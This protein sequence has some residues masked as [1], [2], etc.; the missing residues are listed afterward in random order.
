MNP[1]RL[2]RTVV[3]SRYAIRL[4]PD[5]TTFTFAGDE[6]VTV[7][8]VEPVTEIRLNAVELTITAVII[9]NAR[10]ES[11]HGTAHA[12]PADERYR[13]TFPAPIAPGEWRLRLAFTGTLNDKL[14][15]FYR[16][17]YKD[18]SGVP[19]ALAATQPETPT[20]NALGLV[21]ATIETPKDAIAKTDDAVKAR[22]AARQVSRPDR[23]CCSGV[24][25]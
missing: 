15:G 19:H 25:T 8:V 23:A 18:P 16:S 12:E 20:F 13:L 4:A 9:E 2:P 14:R 6:T 1:H 11:H 22:A 24:G 10:S 21:M 7:T 5:L 3:P 17:T